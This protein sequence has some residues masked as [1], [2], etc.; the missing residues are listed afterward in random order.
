MHIE[1]HADA[2][3]YFHDRLERALSRLRLDV[4]VEA[5]SFHLDLLA[6][7]LTAAGLDEPLVT[8]LAQ[9]FATE[10]PHER[11][12]RFREAGDGALHG[13]GFFAEHFESRGV[14]R[15][16]VVGMGARAYRQAE[17]AGRSVRQP[18]AEIFCELADGFDG[19]ACA[20]ADVREETALR[21][22]QD[23]VRLL[24]RYRA[25]RSPL[26]A[27]RL[28]AAGV[29]PQLAGRERTLH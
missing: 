26:L 2:R 11:F 22:P 4:S 6:R 14:S 27:Q 25:T 20:L 18:S 24:D 23:I 29:F 19:F 15:D 7:Q 13:C 21:T 12:R 17:Q 28:E 5:R 1:A 16:Y 8:R 3:G 9:A 10:E